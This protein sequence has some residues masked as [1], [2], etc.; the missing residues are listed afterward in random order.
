PFRSKPRGLRALVADDNRLN[1]RVIG[2]MLETAGY[3]VVFA[4]NGDD[5]LEIMDSGTINIVLMD[6]NMPVLNGLDATKHYRVSALD[7]PHLP[8]IGLTADATPRMEQRCL[9]AGMDSCITK[10]IDAHRLLSVMEQFA[11]KA[12]TD[13]APA[14]SETAANIVLLPTAET[15]EG[16]F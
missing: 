10:P 4:G 2:K 13:A 6:V 9:E 16:S 1:R 3:D 12:G 8:I 7:L 14:P 5:A 11:G 15:N